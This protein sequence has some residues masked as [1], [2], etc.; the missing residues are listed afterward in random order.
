MAKRKNGP[1]TRLIVIGVS[2][3]VQPTYRLSI[4]ETVVKQKTF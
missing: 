2:W 3:V 1:I 4:C